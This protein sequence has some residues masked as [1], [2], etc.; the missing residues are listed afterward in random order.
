MEDHAL[1][2][3]GWPRSGRRGEGGREGQLNVALYAQ[4]GTT[5]GAIKLH[6]SSRC[7]RE[8]LEVSTA[9]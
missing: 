7:M 4:R 3:S 1:M 5:S 6:C 2:L 9:A 8:L